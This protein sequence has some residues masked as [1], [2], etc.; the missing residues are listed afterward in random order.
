MPR[1]GNGWSSK[2]ESLVTSRKL[3]GVNLAVLV[4]LLA[5]SSAAILFRLGARSLQGWDEGV[6]AEVSKEML[7]TGDWL[8]PH[9]NAQ[10][11]FEKPPLMMWITASLF[12]VFGVK[13]FC[14]RAASAFAG[15]LLILA[16]Y[17]SGKK[18][19]GRAVGILA[20]AILLANFAYL[21]RARDGRTDVLL[22]LFIYL[23]VLAYQYSRRDRRFW[24][25]IG[26][27]FGLA[28]MTK[29]WAALVIPPVLLV[30]MFVDGTAKETLRSATLWRSVGPA[31]I[32]VIPWHL[33]M[34]VLHP[35]AFIDRYFMYDL[36][37]RST[38]NLPLDG[39]TPLY[40]FNTI[41]SRFI[42][43]DIMIPFAAVTNLHYLLQKGRRLS[44]PIYLILA[45][46]V[47]GVYTLAQ[48][49]LVWYV[50][51]IYPGLCILIAAMIVHAFRSHH[52]VAFS[53][54][55]LSLVLSLLNASWRA[56]GLLLLAPAAIGLALLGLSWIAERSAP[57]PGTEPPEQRAEPP[58]PR[59]RALLNIRESI[60]RTP[61]TTVALRAFVSIVTIFFAGRSISKARLAYLGTVA[62]L[63]TLSRTAGRSNPQASLLAIHIPN[64]YYSD[65]DVPAILF[66][67]DR[68][69]ITIHSPEQLA[70]YLADMQVHEAV[71]QLSTM[72][73]LSAEYRFGIIA[74][75]PPFVYATMEKIAP[76]GP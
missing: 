19:F 33:A 47:F 18:A 3:L 51:P 4:L 69:V 23:C 22:T 65:V 68:P 27:F 75:E 13:E 2:L 39:S 12:S 24:Y 16:T 57:Q 45:S 50:F 44:E 59:Q 10:P 73:V 35:G 72:D 60:R 29:S 70:S 40:F 41:T 36:V 31:A 55:V 15:I 62:P 6:Y 66:Y 67:S 14:A 11:W 30:T 74:Q 54:L 49:R 9:F 63:A 5:V 37:E 71:L 56:V 32:L 25:A 58:R 21:W 26:F 46:L 48:T 42:T 52:D 1:P 34:L 20:S 8:T 53:G 17:L 61:R 64:D 43:W 7:R 76:G 38:T 28:F